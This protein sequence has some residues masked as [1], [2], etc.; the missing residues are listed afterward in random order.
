MEGQRPRVKKPAEIRLLLCGVV[1][2][3][4]KILCSLI[5][6]SN[7]GMDVPASAPADFRD[8]SRP[9][10]GLRLLRSPLLRWYS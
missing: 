5:L 4:S 7:A 1:G 2:A 10:L 6:Q 8:E 9:L 3:L